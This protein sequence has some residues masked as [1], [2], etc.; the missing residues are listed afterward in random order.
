VAVNAGIHPSAEPVRRVT[1]ERDDVACE[2]KDV[3]RDGKLFRR[4]LGCGGREEGAL[5]HDTMNLDALF[6]QDADGKATVQSTR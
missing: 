3:E 5:E 1:Y 6:A 2:R 4:L